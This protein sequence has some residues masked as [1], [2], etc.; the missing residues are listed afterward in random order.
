MDTITKQEIKELKNNCLA[1]IE[2]AKTANRG[3]TESEKAFCES[4]YTKM[5]ELRDADILAVAT[6]TYSKSDA[7]ANLKSDFRS[8]LKNGESLFSALNLNAPRFGVGQFLRAAVIGPRNDYERF[9]VNSS[10]DSTGGFNLPTDIAA[11]FI[12]AWRSQ[13]VYLTAGGML[14]PMFDRWKASQVS[15]PVASFRAED[16][17]VTTAAPFA[18]VDLEGKTLSVIIKVSREQLED[19][20]NINSEIDRTLSSALALAA[21]KSI[22]FGAAGSEPLGIV[23]TSNILS[24]AAATNG[25]SLDDYSKLIEAVYQLQSNN[26]Q[27]S[28]VI[29]SPREYKAVNGFADT[30]GQPLLKPEGLRNIPFVVSPSVPTNQTQGSSTDASTIIVGDF[31]RLLVAARVGLRVEVLKERFADNNQYGFQAT[32]RLD[33]VPTRAKSFCKVVGLIP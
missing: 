10:S 20:I 33:S 24:V 5:E 29:M 11:Q 23:G 17:S 30:T 12:D 7:T 18:S 2:T 15:D 8:P 27:P 21:D 3:L 28:A 31:S 26:A 22:G 14:L 13:S 32:M 4:T 6:S 16:A 19:S 1:V 9:A 25:D